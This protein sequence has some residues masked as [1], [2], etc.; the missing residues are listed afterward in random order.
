MDKFQNKYRISSHRKPNWDYSFDGI[1]FITLAIQDRKCIL[2]EIIDDRMVLSD[3]GLIV[4]TEWEKSFHIRNELFLDEYVI[5][6]NHIHGIIFLEKPNNIGGNVETHGR[7]SLRGRV[8]LP[9]R[10]PKSISSFVAGFK[11]RVNTVVNNYIDDN[12][13]DIP[14]YNKYNRFF[15]P[16]YYDHII[17]NAQSLKNIRNYIVNNP[18]NWKKDELF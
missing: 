5:M 12:L 6:P 10:R 1:Y 3:Y 8:S 14:K 11:S 9:H 18:L 4:K 7:V 2:G 16:N 13:L 15:Q 17:Q